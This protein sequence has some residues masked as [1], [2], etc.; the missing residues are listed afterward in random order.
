MN[1]LDI[2]IT[3]RPGL[4]AHMRGTSTKS[5][6]GWARKARHTPD[7]LVLILA[8]YPSTSGVRSCGVDVTLVRVVFSPQV[9]QPPQS[10][11]PSRAPITT[12]TPHTGHGSL[13]AI[14]FVDD[15]FAVGNLNKQ[16]NRS[17]I[18]TNHAPAPCSFTASSP[19]CRCM[20]N[21]DAL[22]RF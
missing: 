1:M 13:D 21:A 14:R 15:I 19:A 2:R 17:S 22:T 8:Q 7:G 6:T 18:Q 3:N 10:T 16:T 9:A 4:L 11:M 20:A 12:P 5:R